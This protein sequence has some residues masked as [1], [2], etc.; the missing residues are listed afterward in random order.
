MGRLS[1]LMRKKANSDFYS[2]V[3]KSVEIALAGTGR[4]IGTHL[5]KV[6]ISFASVNSK[7]TV[8]K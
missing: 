8:Q 1:C 3:Q 4:L 7:Y 6:L 2:E 5:F